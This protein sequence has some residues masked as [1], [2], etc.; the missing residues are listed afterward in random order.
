MFFNANDFQNQNFNKPVHEAITIR[1]TTITEQEQNLMSCFWSQWDEIPKHVGVFKVSLR[2]S[3]LSVNER[4]E[5]NW[6]TE[7]EDGGVVAH[8]IPNAFIGVEFNSETSWIA[9]SIG[10]TAF[11]T[12]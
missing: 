6:V 9:S 2:V 8:Q 11:A 1:S 12:F 7:E 10:R 3:L 5:E 4:R